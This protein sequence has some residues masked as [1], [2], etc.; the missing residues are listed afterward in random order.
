MRDLVCESGA[1]V[2]VDSSHA[3]DLV[4]PEGTE[5]V[6]SLADI[7]VGACCGELRPR[8]RAPIEPASCELC[9]QFAPEA[10]APCSLPD[11]CTPRLIDCFYSCCCYGSTTWAQCDGETWHV[12]TDCSPKL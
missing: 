7:T 10:G 9:P 3:S 11:D 4:C 1:W 5:S 6:T 12:T 2:T 8:N